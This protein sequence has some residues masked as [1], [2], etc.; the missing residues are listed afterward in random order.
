M[1]RRAA[2]TLSAAL[3]LAALAGCAGIPTAGEIA[4]QPWPAQTQ[5]AGEVAVEAQG[6]AEGARPA[7]IVDGFLL[8]MAEY[9]PGYTTAK[10]YLTEGAAEAWRP[11]SSVSIYTDMAGLTMDGNTLAEIESPQLVGQ[12]D[13]DGVYSAGPPGTT[14]SLVF[15]LVRDATGEWRIARLPTIG[16]DA[17]GAPQTMGVIVTRARFNNAYQRLDI[18]YFDDQG[19][20]LIPDTRYLPRSNFW[21]RQALQALLAGPS[22]RV[23]D[24][25]RT[26][27]VSGISLA[28]GADPELQGT[29]VV[30][31]LSEASADLT[32]GEA[33][34]L[35]L[36]CAATL[37][38]VTGVEA[39]RLTVGGV[40]LPVDGAALDGSLPVSAVTPY[41]AYATATEPELFGV[42]GGVVTGVTSG[43]WESDLGETER[44]ILSLAVDADARRAVVVT[45]AGLTEGAAELDE[46]P[47]LIE[48][49]GLIRPQFARDGR[50]WAMAAGDTGSQVW[51]VNG[52]TVAE[53]AAPALEGRTVKAFRLAPDGRR[54]AL[55]VSVPAEDGT[56]VF[57]LGLAEVRYAADGTPSVEGWREVPV[58]VTE[59]TLVAMDDV[60]WELPSTLVVVGTGPGAEVNSLFR[61]PLD[62]L[63]SVEDLGRPGEPALAAVATTA[64]GRLVVLDESGR[65]YRWRDTHE[66]DSVA[67]GMSALAYPG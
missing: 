60:A 48:A 62:G 29:V 41:D 58:A 31:P 36:M 6:P 57:Q 64:S 55:V 12:L 63:E 32:R 11:G 26:N 28:D 10:Q 66:W 19:E 1:T 44:E 17:D 37:R 24:I 22:D 40:T 13:P 5:N 7:Q 56:E 35:A 59:G 45:P 21:L 34:R 30:I 15:G 39:V 4:S 42:R 9:E 43:P 53:V 46:P 52:A 38:S 54:L 49:E 2:V 33:T 18:Y 14:P 23:K 20:V 65:V 51:V 67:A 47:E 61:V 16:T 27:L 50:L 8:A 3:A 25:I